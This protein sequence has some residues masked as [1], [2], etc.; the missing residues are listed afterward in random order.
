MNIIHSALT[1]LCFAETKPSPAG[2]FF[3]FAG[4]ERVPDRPFALSLPRSA[5]RLLVYVYAVLLRQPRN[6]NRRGRVPL[7]KG[8]AI[9]LVC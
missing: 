9:N 4:C 7:S 8:P 6:A 1:T 2:G 3:R 5:L